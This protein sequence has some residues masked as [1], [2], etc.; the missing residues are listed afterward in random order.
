MVAFR[1]LEEDDFPALF[2]ACYP[3]HFRPRLFAE[4]R[5]S[6]E[7]QQRG[8]GCHLLALID[9]R[10]IGT[11]QLIHH[12]R[13]TEIADVIISRPYRGQGIG[14][15]LIAALLERART[16]G[17]EPVEIVVEATNPR[18]RALYE[19]LGFAF[20]RQIELGSGEK[21]DLLIWDAAGFPGGLPR[22]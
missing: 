18:A 4:L 1:L 10:P 16:D 19:R 21:G 11:A 9:D 13:K 8:A 6:L 5:R 17:W 2:Q 22:G 3:G 12:A 7:R 20:E 14:S 15:R